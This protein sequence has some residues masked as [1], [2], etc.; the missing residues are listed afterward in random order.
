M[1]VPIE[2]HSTRQHMNQCDV[3]DSRLTL[4]VVVNRFISDLLDYSKHHHVVNGTRFSY[5]TDK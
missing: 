1:H 3:F 4:F 5:R 2:I